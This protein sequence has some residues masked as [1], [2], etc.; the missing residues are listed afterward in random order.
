MS[1]VTHLSH[2][3][4]LH[5]NSSPVEQSVKERGREWDTVAETERGREGLL[6]VSGLSFPSQ[7]LQPPALFA[8]HS[9]GEATSPKSQDQAAH[10]PPAGEII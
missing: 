5:P 3:Q 4:Y 7:A 1:E 9:G 8:A 6:L 2:S 10:S